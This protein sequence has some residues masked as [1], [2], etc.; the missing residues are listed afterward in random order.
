MCD[1]FRALLVEAQ[2]SFDAPA[3]NLRVRSAIEAHTAPF[4]ELISQAE[5]AIDRKYEEIS[6]LHFASKS[7]ISLAMTLLDAHALSQRAI[8]AVED[9]IRTAT[10][11]DGLLDRRIGKSIAYAVDPDG[12]LDQRIGA[13]IASAVSSAIASTMDENSVSYRTCVLDEWHAAEADIH[14]ARKS[15][16]TDF[17]DSIAT[18]MSDGIDTLNATLR[19]AAAE[20]RA[21]RDSVVNPITH[22]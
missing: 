16:E 22:A 8:A 12:L 6:A 1:A 4:S 3:I 10:A 9:A 14:A 20:F 11:P 18:I 21:K 15:A 19:C 7:T 17:L 2:T 13:S 5:S